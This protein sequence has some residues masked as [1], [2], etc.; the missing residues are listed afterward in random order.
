MPANPGNIDV[1]MKAL[2]MLGLKMRK[3]TGSS[4]QAETKELQEVQH[5]G[6]LCTSLQLKISPRFLYITRPL[7][8]KH[9]PL[10]RLR[11]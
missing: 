9:T 3:S 6:T 8:I 7:K 11:T 5:V 10:I 1:A 2:A 4:C